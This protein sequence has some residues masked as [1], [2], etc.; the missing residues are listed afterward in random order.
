[1][2]TQTPKVTH[3]HTRSA[4]CQQLTLTLQDV[5]SELM[6]H[7]EV[8]KIDD[9]KFD[10]DKSE[11]FFF[12][13][14]FLFLLL[15]LTAELV[16]DMD[17]NDNEDSNYSEDSWDTDSDLSAD[18]IAMAVAYF[19]CLE[20]DASEVKQLELEATKDV[21][22]VAPGFKTD[23]LKKTYAPH[24]LPWDMKVAMPHPTVKGV[25]I[26]AGADMPHV[27]KKSRNTARNTGFEKH[28]RD[29]MLDGVIMSLPMLYGAETSWI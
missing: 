23:P 9:D 22:E 4:I 11:V 27:V 3:Y 20:D 7:N 26:F 25:T 2:R 19:D 13:F 29:L 1:M 17:V 18:E 15:A 6:K 28:T 10:G 21:T 12:I 16:L 14:T 24:E 5:F 8:L